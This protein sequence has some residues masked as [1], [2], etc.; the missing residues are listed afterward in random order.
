MSSSKKEA[1]KTV[2]KRPSTTTI[3]E[4][5]L[6]HINSYQNQ[7][8][9]SK[10]RDPSP[11]NSFLE[12]L[13]DELME[14][15]M[16]NKMKQMKLALGRKK[17]KDNSTEEITSVLLHCIDCALFCSDK[18]DD[19][20]QFGTI[21]SAISSQY[22]CSDVLLSRLQEASVAKLERIRAQA[23]CLLAHF[24]RESPSCVE[25]LLQQRFL[26]KTQAVR[27]AALKGA[28]KALAVI[29]EQ[30]QPEEAERMTSSSSEFRKALQWSCCHD[31]SWTNRSAALSTMIN[32]E[33]ILPRVRDVKTQVR[34]QAIQKL[35]SFA[36]EDWTAQQCATLTQSALINERCDET[37]N[38]AKVLVCTRWMK[39]AK[40]CPIN[41]LSHLQPSLYEKECETIIKVLIDADD[42]TLKELSAAEIG[43]FRKGLNT[44]PAN[45]TS[46]TLFLARFICADAP[47]RLSSLIADIPRL[48]ELLTECLSKLATLENKYSDDLKKKDKQVEEKEEELICICNQLFK[49]ADLCDVQEEGSRRH[50]IE[51]CTEFLITLETPEEILEEALIVLR[52]AHINEQEFLDNIMEIVEG[53][54]SQQNDEQVQL[55]IVSIM[56]PVL[57]STSIILH[58]EHFMNHAISAL[59]SQN[60]ILREAGVACLG[61]LALFSH[62]CNPT[63]LEVMTKE[64]EMV[65][66]RAQAVLAVTDWTMTHNDEGT[67]QELQSHVSRLLVH[68]NTSVNAL[69]AEVSTKLL[70]G[71]QVKN[72][73]MIA[74][75][76]CL[77]FDKKFEDAKDKNDIEVGSVYRM[78]QLLCL[79]FPAYSMKSQDN[80]LLLLAAM[81]PMLA[82]VTYDRPKGSR[83]TWPIAKLVEYFYSTLQAGTEQELSHLICYEIAS[84]LIHAHDKLTNTHLKTLCKLLGGADI[85]IENCDRKC[86]LKLKSLLSE[87]SML[88]SEPNSLE[89]LETIMEVLED[90]PK[91][92]EGTNEDETEEKLAETLEMVHLND[93][94]NNARNS[95]ISQNSR[96]GENNARNSNI[97]QNSGFSH[98][99]NI[100]Q[101]SKHSIVS[102]RSTRSTRSTKRMSPGLTPV[103]S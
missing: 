58:E 67:S 101:K 19:V 56:T 43:A 81:T 52:K 94:E 41:L 48:C 25:A 84:F 6:K 14:V 76:L 45:I 11:P 93:K 1:S 30:Q 3:R 26:D 71:G 83:R 29:H 82:K 90:V 103:N 78:D 18:V 13:N 98:I 85:D 68:E 33:D 36:L 35:H 7:Q 53:L 80:K 42:E 44:V 89:S 9:K 4:I 21:L 75:L 91:E 16:C 96:F 65:D 61:R 73:E 64:D 54:D 46:E 17:E 95:D 24:H 100:S 12:R 77:Y 59:M 49:L 22:G 62:E 79:F 99:S 57:E 27:H 47:E 88:I 72:P 40:Y 34:V 60:D 97:S 69:A 31:P 102:T 86:L 63:L 20:E 28:V 66:I 37:R 5:I 10:A 74:S 51:R 8:Q 87:L 2:K 15:G 55:R 92:S 38:V 32:L 50:F 23:C 39:A 70:L